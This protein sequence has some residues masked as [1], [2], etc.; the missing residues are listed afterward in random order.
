[1]YKSAICKKTVKK[2]ALNAVITRMKFRRKGQ[3][4]QLVTKVLKALDKRMRKIHETATISN[5]TYLNEYLW[6]QW[7]KSKLAFQNS[8]ED[9]F[10]TTN[11]V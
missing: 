8:W 1:M 4:N 7:S 10:S 6:T 2:T 3:N 9:R 5:L 11:R